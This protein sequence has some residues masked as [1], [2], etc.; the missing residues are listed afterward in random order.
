MRRARLLGT[1]LAT[2]LALGLLGLLTGCPKREAV[3]EAPLDGP[4]IDAIVALP[5]EVYFAN[6]DASYLVA[7]SRDV[8][9]LSGQPEVAVEAAVREL[10]AGPRESGS[11]ALLPKTVKLR[12]ATM[13]DGEAVIDLN[14]AFVDDFQGGSGVAQLAVYSLVNTAASVDGVE[15]VRLTVE[16]QPI[17]DFAGVLDLSEALTPDLSLLGGEALSDSL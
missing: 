1:L 2:L 14:Q 16:G 3:D 9:G 13:T 7:E 10:L 5:V 12:G 8:P 15:R 6:D 17:G 11:V 4:P